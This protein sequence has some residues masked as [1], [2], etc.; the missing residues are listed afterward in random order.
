MYKARFTKWGWHKYN[1]KSRQNDIKKGQHIVVSK[2][3]SCVR[4]Q[5]KSAGTSPAGDRSDMPRNL[6]RKAIRLNST[7]P[8]GITHCSQSELKLEHALTTTRNFIHGNVEQHGDWRPTKFSVTFDVFGGKRRPIFRGRMGYALD[9]LAETKSSSAWN[10]LR[11][12]FLEMEVALDCPHPYYALDLFVLVPGMILMHDRMDILKYY[13]QHLYALM[14]RRRGYQD[15]LSIP[16]LMITSGQT[17]KNTLRQHLESLLMVWLDSFT[18]QCNKAYLV[19]LELWPRISYYFKTDII[20]SRLPT[21]VSTYRRLL[22]EAVQEY[23]P[24][25]YRALRV[26]ASFLAFQ[27]RYK[28]YQEDFSRTCALVLAGLQQRDTAQDEWNFRL[29]LAEHYREIGDSETAA[30]LLEPGSKETDRLVETRDFNGLIRLESAIQEFSRLGKVKKVTELR[31]KVRAFE[32]RMR[33]AV[34][35]MYGVDAMG[36]VEE[37]RV[38][39]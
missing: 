18:D 35:K 39:T 14:R 30:S 23:G 24:R 6:A 31:E 13:F 2:G 28:A 36:N 8:R 3:K 4:P 19:C 5:A 25:N 27:I 29:I 26:V 38:L 20:G 11:Q 33:S 15:L 1:S 37:Q 7:L 9:H 22:L 16:Q 32:R 34:P 12:A 21:V 17:D 10:A